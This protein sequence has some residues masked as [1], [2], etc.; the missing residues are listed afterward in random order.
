MRGAT[1]VDRITESLLDEF[2]KEHEISHLPEEKRFEHFSSFITVRRHYGESFDT[3]DIVVGSGGDTS[4]DGIAIIVNAVLVT[5][6]EMF[7]EMAQQATYL[8]VTF[9]FVQAERSANFDGAKISS[10]GL[11]VLD[12]FSDTPRLRRNESIS[13]AAEIMSAIFAHSSKFKRSN[14]TCKIYYVTTGKWV[15]DSDLEARRKHVI[16]DLENTGNFSEV[17]FTAID[18]A[19]VQKYYRETKNAIAADFVFAN[20]AVIPDIPGVTQAYLGFLPFSEFLKLVQNEDREMKGGLFYDNVRDWL[21][22]NE[23]NTEIKTTL[24]SPNRSRFVLMNNGIT[25][26]SRTVQPTGNKFHLEDYQIVNGCQ[27][28]HVLFDNKDVLDDSVMVPLRLIGAQD[29]AVIN[30]VI[31]ATNRQTEVRKEQLFALQEFP[32]ELEIYFQTFPSSQR[33]YY[34]RRDR[35]YDRSEIEK[36]RIVTPANLIRAFAAMFLKEPHRTTRN[37]AALANKV[38]EEIFVKGHRHEPYYTAA[39]ALY[40][41]EYFFRSGRLESKYKPARFHILLALRILAVGDNLPR[42]NSHDMERCSKDLMGAL[43]DTTKA[44]ELITRAASIVDLAAAGDFHRDRIRTEPFTKRIAELCQAEIARS[45][46][47]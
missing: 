24:N 9:I 41:L 5:D 19:T 27:T 33:L 42:M 2:T 23:V 35:Q 39:F 40:K 45:L 37:Y 7:S 43:W 4:I 38:G 22:Y 31:K 26:I 47:K 6:V 16:E 3:E 15:G 11:G 25:V 30:D 12:F 8:D 46:P 18:A 29:E 17:D 21:A 14:P 32:K 13:A 28:T 1:I 34:E 10:I 44:D 36:T 20:N